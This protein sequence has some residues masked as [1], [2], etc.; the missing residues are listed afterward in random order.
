MQAGIKKDTAAPA[1]EPH[2]THLDART[3]EHTLQHEARHGN[4]AVCPLGY[5]QMSCY[6]LLSR[7]YVLR[8]YISHCMYC[9]R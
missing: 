5:I 2:E 3:V 4:T 1:Y 7:L 8:P 6:L 9:V